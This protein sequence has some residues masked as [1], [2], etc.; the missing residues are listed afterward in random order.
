MTSITGYIDYISFEA[1]SNKGGIAQGEVF[2]DPFHLAPM[3][4]ARMNYTAQKVVELIPAEATKFV[5]AWT[6]VVGN[7]VIGIKADGTEV[8]LSLTDGEVAIEAGVYEKAKYEYDNIV[9]PQNDLPILNAHV[10]GLALR[11]KARRIAIFYS[12]MAA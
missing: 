10:E 3:T 6:P 9:I 8:E 12:Q 5:P 11:A 7:V 1:G 2:N 4:D